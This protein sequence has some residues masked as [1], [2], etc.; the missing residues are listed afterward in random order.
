MRQ[1]RALL[2]MAIQMLVSQGGPAFGHAKAQMEGWLGIL[3]QTDERFR[4]LGQAIGELIATITGPFIHDLYKTITPDSLTHIFD[5]ILP[6]AKELGQKLKE[7]SGVVPRLGDVFQS[8]TG[9]ISAFGRGVFSAFNKGDGQEG[10]SSPSISWGTYEK[11]LATQ[12]S[13]YLDIFGHPK[14]PLNSLP[15]PISGFKL[16]VGAKL[17]DVANMGFR[18]DTS[19]VDLSLFDKFKIRLLEPVY[20]LFNNVTR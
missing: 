10:Y 1:S 2:D 17:P 3:K 13:N 15:D 5:P 12:S 4:D 7:L 18:L 8:L 19:N 20:D 14:Y 16:N 6:Q 9:D 11:K